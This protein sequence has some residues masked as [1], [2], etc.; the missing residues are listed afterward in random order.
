MDT[1]KIVW[2]VDSC[3][4]ESI[5]LKSHWVLVIMDQFSR[6]IV[7]FGVHAGDVDD[8]LIERLIGNRVEEPFEEHILIICFSGTLKTWGESWPHSN[9]ITTNI[10]FINHW[11]AIL[12]CSLSI[13]LKSNVLNLITIS[14][15]HTAMVCFKCQSL[16]ES[17]IR[18]G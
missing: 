11:Q 2:S 4:C 18:H 5:L 9:T 12:P 17:R 8:I 16:L 7:G 14:G 1:P 10:E 6:R 15:N 13:A 3:R